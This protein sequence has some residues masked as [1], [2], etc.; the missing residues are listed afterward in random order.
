IKCHFLDHG[1]TDLLIP[2]QLRLLDTKLNKSLPYQA[3]EVSLYGLEEVAEN[4]TVLEALFDFALGKT[5]VAEVV[6]REEC[7][8]VILFDTFGK[9]DVNINEKI[10]KTYQEASETSLLTSHSSPIGSVANLLDRPSDTADRPLDSSL[11]NKSID[12]QSSSVSSLSDTS[13]CA[14]SPN[15]QDTPESVTLSPQSSYIATLNSKLETGKNTGSEGP[16]LTPARQF[17]STNVQS[18]T[19][20]VVK[21]QLLVR[22]KSSDSWETEESE[23]EIGDECGVEDSEAIQNNSEEISNPTSVS[24]TKQSAENQSVIICDNSSG[25]EDVIAEASQPS[26]L[27]TWGTGK[28]AA[29]VLDEDLWDKEAYHRRVVPPHHTLPPNGQFCDIHIGFVFDPANFVVVFAYQP[30]LSDSCITPFESMSDMQRLHQE[31]N[32]YMSE[33]KTEKSLAEEDVKLGH[34]YAGQQDDCWYRTMIRQAVGPELFSVYYPDLGE[35]NVVDTSELQPLPIQ[36]WALPFQAFKAKLDAIRQAKRTGF[37]SEGAI[38][39]MKELTEGKNLVGL[40]RGVDEH[41]VVSLSLVDTSDENIDVCVGDVLV[42]LGFA[43]PS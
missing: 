10:A 14:M 6:S 19:P 25:G 40:V 8:S 33:A 29:V 9:E 11:S 38:F 1:D 7:L 24:V 34:L 42:E 36:F 32:D 30:P 31:L 18:E 5:C 41:K 26:S 23:E 37:W 35:F 39:K 4:I 16:K 22:Q 28:P 20:V 27:Y 21:D 15:K 3:I 13:D 17:S 43:E 2:D 12:T